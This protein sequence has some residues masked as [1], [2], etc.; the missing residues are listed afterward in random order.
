MADTRQIREALVTRVLEGDGKASHAQRR[1]AFNNKDLAEP[2]RMV[3]NKVATQPT[4]IT[5][6][7]SP[8]QG[9]GRERGS[10]LRA[11]GLRRHW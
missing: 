6:G 1:A 10:D 7:T 11:S 2:L 8:G 5:D 9:G 3:V 4:Q